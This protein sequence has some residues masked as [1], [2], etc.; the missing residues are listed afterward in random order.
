MCCTV[1]IDSVLEFI[2]ILLNGTRGTLAFTHINAKSFMTKSQALAFDLDS[3]NM[4]R[5]MRNSLDDFFLY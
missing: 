5:A 3:C 4:M 1:C 2:I